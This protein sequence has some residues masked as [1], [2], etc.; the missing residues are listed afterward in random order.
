MMP[1]AKKQETKLHSIVIKKN[2]QKPDS[3]KTT[4]ANY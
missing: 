1:W 4:K 3:E 2:Y